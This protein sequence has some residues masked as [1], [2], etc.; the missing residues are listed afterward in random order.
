MGSSISK[1]IE[2][3]QEQGDLESVRQ[4]HTLD[5]IFDAKVEADADKIHDGGRT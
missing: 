1:A 5:E 3:Q 2:E 4:L